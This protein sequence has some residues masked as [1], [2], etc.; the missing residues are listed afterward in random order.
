MAE[1][2]VHLNLM[3][4]ELEQ[5]IILLAVLTATFSPVLFRIIR[6]KTN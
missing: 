1:I 4:V 3:T 2:G 5:Q 6:S